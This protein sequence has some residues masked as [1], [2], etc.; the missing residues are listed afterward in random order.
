MINREK[1]IPHVFSRQSHI[2]TNQMGIPKSGYSSLA[3]TLPHTPLK[4]AKLGSERVQKRCGRRTNGLGR[5]DG[6]TSNF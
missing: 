4:E 6:R 3:E 2:L 1:H 5:T